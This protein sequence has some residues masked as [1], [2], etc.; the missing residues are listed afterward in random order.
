MSKP[1]RSLEF[2]KLTAGVQVVS[3]PERRTTPRGQPCGRVRVCRQQGAGR[4]AWFF[5]L[6][7]YGRDRPGGARADLLERL[8]GL[9]PGDRIK[10]HG[11]LRYFEYADEHGRPRAGHELIVESLT[12]LEPS[13][14]TMVEAARRLGGEL[15]PAE[16][17]GADCEPPAD[18]TPTHARA[19]A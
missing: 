9:R 1:T 2:C 15:V 18:W 6:T 12:T 7:V 5:T 17:E 19:P 8:L 13:A 10:V 16:D 4:P 11:A 14:T 3:A